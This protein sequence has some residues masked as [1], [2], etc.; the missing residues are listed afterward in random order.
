MRP[1]YTQVG[2]P[3][4]PLMTPDIWQD[5]EQSDSDVSLTTD[6]D[7]QTAPPNRWDPHPLPPMVSNQSIESSDALEL[8]LRD[9]ERVE[10]FNARK[11]ASLKAKRQRMDEKIYRRRELEDRKWNAIMEARSRRDRRIWERRRREDAAFEHAERDLDEEE[12]VSHY[13]RIFYFRI[14]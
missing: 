13:A 4:T 6:G 11:R 7:Y 3:T 8:R 9:I 5:P 1:L 10:D 2:K 14:C 12:S